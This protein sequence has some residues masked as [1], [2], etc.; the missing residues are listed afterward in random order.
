MMQR[1]PLSSFS[2]YD[3]RFNRLHT[4]RCHQH[5]HQNAMF[6]SWVRHSFALC[7]PGVSTCSFL[8]VE[9]EQVSART[10]IGKTQAITWNEAAPTIAAMRADAREHF[11]RTGAKGGR[12]LTS[13]INVTADG[14][15]AVVGNYHSSNF[16]NNGWP[17]DLITFADRNTLVAVVCVV[18][19]VG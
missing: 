4:F 14:A 15:D 17:F 7:F 8:Q 10:V 11:A 13:Y 6:F 5:A 3:S 1:Q 16:T 19:Y 2:S 9:L 18:A 12:E